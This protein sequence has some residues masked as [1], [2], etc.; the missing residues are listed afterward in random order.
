[1]EIAVASMFFFIALMV[2]FFLGL[3][4]RIVPLLLITSVGVYI[5]YR[6]SVEGGEDAA[7]KAWAF[8]SFVAAYTVAALAAWYHTT[9]KTFLGKLLRKYIVQEHVK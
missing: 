6:L 9:N 2:G 3:V 1:M 7:A 8:S 5:A 4:L